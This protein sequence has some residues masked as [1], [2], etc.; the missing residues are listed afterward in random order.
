MPA[1]WI[2]FPLERV[3]FPSPRPDGP[4]VIE[5]FN[6]LG[7]R[8][9][10]RLILVVFCVFRAVPRRSPEVPGGS[11][12][13]PGGSPEV[14]GGPRRSPEVPGGPRRFACL[15]AVLAIEMAEL[16]CDGPCPAFVIPKALLVPQTSPVQKLTTD[17]CP[18]I[19]QDLRLCFL[20]LGI[21]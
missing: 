17:S 16:T 21:L 11:P 15:L 9:N 18:S 5:N 10:W 12:E 2:V 1:I 4:K 19:S 14:P 3:H 20:C 13:V 6:Y 8:D 7:N